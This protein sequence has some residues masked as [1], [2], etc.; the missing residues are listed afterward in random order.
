MKKTRVRF[1]PSPTGAL[2]VGG[3]R[4][5][6]FNWLYARRHDGVFVLRVEDTDQERSTPEAERKILGALDK[7]GLDWDEG[8]YRQSEKRERYREVVDKLTSDGHLYPCFCT[9][10]ELEAERK[11]MI[12]KNRPPRYSGKC[13][14]LTDAERDDRKANGDP[15]AQRFKVEGA[16]IE[17]DDMV[18][19][20]VSFKTADIGDFIVMRSDGAPV[21]Y[22]ASAVDDIDMQ[23]TDVIRGED[24]LSNT[25]KQIMIMRALGA[26]PPR[27]AHLPIILGVDGQKLSKRKDAPDISDLLN[28]GYLPESINTAMAMLGWAGVKGKQAESLDE[29]AQKFDIAKISRSPAK[30]DPERLENINSKALRQAPDNIL[31]SALR[32]LLDK[33]EFPFEKFDPKQMEMIINAARDA[34]GSPAEAVEQLAQF[35]AK[36][37]ADTQT[38]KFIAMP[39]NLQVRTALTSII[40]GYDTI[41]ADSYKSVIDSLSAQTGLQGGALYKQI[42]AIVAGRIQGP[43]L[44]DLFCALGPDELKKTDF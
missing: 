44:K 23:I 35:A 19:G 11:A 25:P 12:A 17:F 9:A 26:E 39:E 24:H 27:Y 8:P 30:Y 14:K 10:D 31:M 3:A 33:A 6:L 38:E 4:T 2:H 15:F 1:A 16:T 20:R 29:M 7:L 42:R 5:A 21:F 18:R 37:P 34:L 22:L 43:K 36:V 28:S 13:R 32:P 41:D 40:E